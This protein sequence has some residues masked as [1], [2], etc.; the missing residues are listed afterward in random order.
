MVL[1]NDK[2][3]QKAKRA[4][5]RKHKKQA[6]MKG[7][8]APNEIKDAFENESSSSSEEHEGDGNSLDYEEEEENKKFLR[9]K[10]ESNAWRFADPFI[11]DTILKDPEYI[12]QLENA[13]MEEE[14][15]LKM[16]REAVVDKLKDRGDEI[17]KELF[18]G[19][20]EIQEK[21]KLKAGDFSDWKIGFDSEDEVDLKKDDKPEIREF[22]EEEKLKFLQ[23]QKQIKHQKDMEVM[24]SK[25]DRINN[26][27]AKGKVL[28]LHG[29]TGRENYREIVDSKL[30]KVSRND[31][32]I[33]EHDR[34]VEQMLGVNLRGTSK[35]EQPFPFDMETLM[36][37]TKICSGDSITKKPSVK[38]K[39]SIEFVELEDSNENFLDSL[40]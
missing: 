2:W 31:L 9:S 25:I 29:K 15:R 30:N 13:K 4:V 36:Q 33:D 20:K 24:K 32:D 10:K 1:H 21:K 8:I 11:D 16:M 37:T 34:L 7:N 23:L 12:Q 39:K 40:L 6:K 38:K 14:T 35:P 3:K 22:T 19:S 5:E 28:E 26:K 27:V 18:E 17:D